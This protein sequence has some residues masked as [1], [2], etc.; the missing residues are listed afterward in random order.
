MGYKKIAYGYYQISHDLSGIES[1]QLIKS[2]IDLEKGLAP[3]RFDFDTSSGGFADVLGMYMKGQYGINLEFNSFPE[4]KRMA[5]F[6]K[7]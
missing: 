1:A 2:I 3:I 6:Y 7:G 5:V 4:S